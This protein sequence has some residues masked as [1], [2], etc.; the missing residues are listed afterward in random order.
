M[1]EAVNLH[2]GTSGRRILIPH[3]CDGADENDTWQAKNDD[4][5][6]RSALLHCCAMGFRWETNETR[7][8]W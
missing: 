4:R 8:L 6:K 7:M 5:P 2:A 3:D 1:C